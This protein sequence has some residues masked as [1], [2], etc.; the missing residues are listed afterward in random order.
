M[1]I[2]PARALSALCV[3]S[4]VLAVITGQARADLVWTPQAGW[5]VEGDSAL[6][7]LL[8]EEGRN[9]LD[10]MNKARATEEN[11]HHSAAMS[12]Y[13]AVAKKY[14]HSIYAPE[15]LYRAAKLRL[16]RKQYF[17]AFDEFQDVVTRYP[18]SSHFNEIIGE[19]YRI[20]DALLAG[21]RNRY[22]GIIPGFKNGPEALI[23]SRRSS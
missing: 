15:A 14:P 7:S 17:K 6:R 18:N 23:I 8:P 2:T 21:A 16:E 1:P 12:A 3:L 10:S 19:Q 11:G 22:W 5:K 20:A 9:A 13:E 4:L